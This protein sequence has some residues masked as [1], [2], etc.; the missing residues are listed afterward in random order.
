MT[1]Q[2]ADFRESHFN[3]WCL[4]LRAQQ[5][6]V[7]S[8]PGSQ[9]QHLR[10][11]AAPLC[12]LACCL[13]APHLWAINNPAFHRAQDCQSFP[14]NSLHPGPRPSAGPQAPANTPRALSILSLCCHCLEVLAICPHPLASPLSG[15]GKNAVPFFY[16]ALLEGD[17]TSLS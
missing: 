9:S 11:A 4:G 14:S 12:S 8:S 5:S 1:P 10:P 2:S 15:R 6:P 3:N 7:P 16:P 13:C 17:F